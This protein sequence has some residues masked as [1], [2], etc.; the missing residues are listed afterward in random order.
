[1]NAALSIVHDPLTLLTF[2]PD[3]RGALLHLLNAEQ[4]ELVALAIAAHQQRVAAQV[5]D[6]L[7]DEM[8]QVHAHCWPGKVHEI[9]VNGAIEAHLVTLYLA[10]PN[11]V[12][13]SA[14]EVT[15]LLLQGRH[16]IIG[17]WTERIILG[18]ADGSC[19]IHAVTSAHRIGQILVNVRV[20]S[21]IALLE[22]AA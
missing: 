16:P 11:A 4:L 5:L 12:F 13:H 18:L 21:H 17:R 20:K 9:E 1:M 19:A 6:D 15:S 2:R 22:L 14:A 7:A 8:E 10:G 3:V